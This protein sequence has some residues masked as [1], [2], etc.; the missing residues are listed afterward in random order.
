VTVGEECDTALP[1]GMFGCSA[2]CQIPN[3]C[4]DGELGGMETCDYGAANGT[5]S[6]ACSGT[7]VLNYCG[8]GDV[9]AASDPDRNPF[10]QTGVFAEQ[11]DDAG[12]TSGDGCSNVCVDEWVCGDGNVDPGEVCDD[13]NT[14]SNDGCSG[15]SGAAC[16]DTQAMGFTGCKREEICGD[17]VRQFA[18]EQCDDGNMTNGDGC[19]ATC[20]VEICGDGVRQS[21][22]GEECDQGSAINGTPAGVCTSACLNVICGNHRVESPYET[23]DDG[24]QMPGDG[25]SSGCQFEIN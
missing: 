24:N 18:T 14:A 15:C 13:G 5:A 2:S 19:S 9:D 23:C 21:G 25:C 17:G 1:P 20:V 6:S 22:V 7:C 4:G 3:Y 11:C 8:D 10:T 16:A 12:N